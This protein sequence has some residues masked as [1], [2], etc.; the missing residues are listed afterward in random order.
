V[1]GAVGRRPCPRT[2]TGGLGG[3]TN[4]GGIGRSR[5]DDGQAVDG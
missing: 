1:A 5:N 2:A 4:D 3:T